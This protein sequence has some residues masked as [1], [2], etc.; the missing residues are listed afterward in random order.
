VKN[1]IRFSIVLTRDGAVVDSSERTCHKAA[2]CWSY[3][4]E[5]DSPGDQVWCARISARVGPHTVGTLA[6][7]EE[8]PAF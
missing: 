1:T 3:L 4:L 6:R 8:D 2:S 7:C 5:N